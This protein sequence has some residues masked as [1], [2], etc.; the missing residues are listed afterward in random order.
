MPIENLLRGRRRVGHGPMVDRSFRHDSDGGVR[1]PLPEGDV[2]GISVGLD[3]CLGLDVEYLQGP[4]GC[5]GGVIS[6]LSSRSHGIREKRKHAIRTFQ[7]QNLLLRVHNRRVCGDWS[8][9]NIIGVVQVDN[10]D[11]VLLVDFLPHTDE[12]VGFEGQCL[13]SGV[14]Q[15]P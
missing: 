11:L 4:T 6:L 13:P 1:Y 7:S 10:D 15:L 2:L 9:Q 3:L 12:M 14:N 5:T 8:T